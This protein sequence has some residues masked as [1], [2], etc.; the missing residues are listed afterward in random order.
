MA[1][2]YHDNESLKAL[3]LVLEDY[4]SWF[5]SLL[6]CLFYPEEKGSLDIVTKPESFSRW[7]I[8]ANGNDI[9]DDTCIGEIIMPLEVIEKLSALNFD[10]FMI[11]DKLLKISSDK[12][13]KP[14]NDEFKKLITIYEEFVLHIRRIEKDIVLEG[15]GYDAFT[16]LRSRKLVFSDI[17]REL[18]RLSRQGKKF[19]I[20]MIKIDNFDSIKKFSDKNESGGYIKL[21]ANLI[22]LSIRSFDDAYYMGENEFIICLKQT[23][24]SGGISALE[25][26]RS[27]LEEKDIV[28][29]L[30][31][32]IDNNEKR[33]LSM[34][35]CI[36]E[37][38]ENDTA[39]E[40]IENLRIDLNNSKNSRSDKV[41]EYHELSPLQRYIKGN[42]GSKV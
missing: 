28:V 2:D 22:K 33:Y 40:L 32:D 30:N 7:L 13:E 24:I 6:D 27:E 16:G 11:A 10:L 31:T 9:N 12:K 41:L 17:N 42:K 23:D 19:C 4:A 25:R 18:Q 1:V 5:C 38:V 37:P 29:S 20:A 8:R 26:L 21:V 39:E 3:L 35:C 15:I 36:A 34:S 14:S